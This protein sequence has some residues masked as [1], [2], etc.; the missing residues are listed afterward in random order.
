MMLHWEAWN[1]A[2]GPR[3][4]HRTNEC[5]VEDHETYQGMMSLFRHA[6]Q[7]KYMATVG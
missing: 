1:C 5:G 7:S 2:T 4:Y 3:D 6:T